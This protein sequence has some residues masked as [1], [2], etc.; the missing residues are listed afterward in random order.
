MRI[1][2]KTFKEWTEEDLL[3]LL[4]NDDFR[5][6]QFLDYKRTFEFLEGDKSQKSKGKDEFRNDVCSFANADGGDLIFG[7]SERNGLASN[8]MPISIDNIDRFELDLRNALLPIMPS[9]PPVDFRFIAVSGGYVVVVHIEKSVFKPYMTVENQT[10]FRFFVRR[11]NRKEA[12]SYSEISNNFLHA[13]SLT[14]EIKRFRLER[15]SELLEDNTGLFGV[16]HVIPSTFRNPSDFIPMCDW[17]KAGK[18]PLPQELNHHVRGRMLPNV[19][20][21]WFPSDDGL[22]DFELLRLFDN[23]IVELK[24]DL[25]IRTIRENEYLVSDEFISAIEDIVEGTAGVYRSLERHATVYVCTSVIGCKG[26]WNYD[27][28]SAIRPAP[29]KVDR[30]RILCAPIEIKDILDAELVG[31]MVEECK[32]RT[33]YALGIK[34]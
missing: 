24:Q 12:M 2:N 20:G 22:R 30:D 8:I 32:K 1:N 18:L 4:D 29:S 10:V 11:G 23:G 31:D 26:Y 27:S 7:I 13:A 15:I 3:I 9:M 19:D 17:G 6:S 14:S 34:R 33:R 21:I 28:A 5:E 25:Y 16:I